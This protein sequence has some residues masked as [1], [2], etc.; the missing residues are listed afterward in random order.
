LEIHLLWFQA[1][2]PGHTS[3]RYRR[4]KKISLRNCV[5]LMFIMQSFDGT[6]SRSLGFGVWTAYTDERVLCIFLHGETPFAR[7]PERQP[8][9]TRLDWAS[10][11]L[12]N[13]NLKRPDSPIH[14]FQYL[15]VSF[16]DPLLVAVLL[17]CFYSIFRV[18]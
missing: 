11:F 1:T 9:A 3:S 10:V 15:V 12:H 17:H 16:N 8:A 6:L 2:I 14:F 5:S 4:K 7:C 18:L 13:P